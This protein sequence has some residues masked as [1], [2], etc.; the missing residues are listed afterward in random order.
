MSS[1]PG[2][3]GEHDPA[4]VVLLEIDPAHQKTLPDFLPTERLCGMRTVDMR[5]LRRERQQAL[6]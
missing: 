4:N 5:A 3:L 1:A 6:V 2:D